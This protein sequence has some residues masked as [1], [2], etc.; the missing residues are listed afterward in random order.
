MGQLPGL[1]QDDG[2][3]CLR[4]GNISAGSQL[5]NYAFISVNISALCMAKVV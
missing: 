4:T 3:Y 1:T 2:S 5:L